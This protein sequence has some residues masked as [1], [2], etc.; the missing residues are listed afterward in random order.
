MAADNLFRAGASRLRI[1][2]FAAAC[3]AGPGMAQTSIRPFV[4]TR[5]VTSTND[6]LDLDNYRNWLELAGGLN[7]DFDLR[8]VDGSL[9]YRVARRVP[10]DT[11]INDKVR[12]TGDGSLRAE[13]LRDYL[14][15]NAQG[16]AS[17]VNPTIGGI[18]NPDSDSLSEQQAYGASVQP[19]F[20]H[21][22]ANRIQATANYRYSIFEA[23]GGVPPL[24]I[25]KP[26]SLDR[27]YYG[28]ASDQRS[29]S[30]SASIGNVRRSDS[31]RLQLSG[32]WQRDRIEQLDEHYDSE[33]VI[34]DGE[35]A[36]TRTVSIVGSGGYED[37]HDE[38]DWCSR[39]RLPGC[40]FS[41][42]GPPAARSGDAAAGQFRFRRTD[43][44]RRRAADAIAAQRTGRAR[45]RAI[46]QLFRQRLL[47]LPAAPRSYPLGRLS[48]QH[49]QLRS[50]LHLAVLRPGDRHRRPGGCAGRRWRRHSRRLAAR[51]RQLHLRLRP[52]DAVLPLQPEPDR[53]ERG[54]PRALRQRH[55]SEGHRGVRR[56]LALLRLRHR[57][58]YPTQL[59]G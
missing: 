57:L 1:G 27:P 50:A 18:I 14:F 13:L 51:R 43:L 19:T 41:I 45:G 7:A 22:F 33:R 6:L 46:W 28:G 39:T 12:H 35:L 48:R 17:M 25:G 26:F 54:V 10:I 31:L 15:L 16:S 53:D 9:N 49:Q 58:L 23:E 55:A 4:E 36:L 2:L 32:D 5:L 42:G 37:I 24:I 20:R 52:L 29:Q 21:I 56:R 47:P 59:F 38:L 40:R 30:G 11:S 44:G 8:R 3:V 34:V